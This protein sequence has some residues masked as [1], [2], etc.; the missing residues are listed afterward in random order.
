MKK[1]QYQNDSP[2]QIRNDLNHQQCNHQV[3][4]QSSPSHPSEPSECHEHQNSQKEN[5]FN[6]SCPHCQKLY[7]SYSA[8]YTHKMR[9]HGLISSKTLCLGIGKKRGRPRKG[10]ETD[11][12]RSSK[13]E[14]SYMEAQ[15]GITINPMKMLDKVVLA[16][17]NCK[18]PHPLHYTLDNALKKIVSSESTCDVVFSEY[19]SFMAGLVR[20]SFYKNVAKFLLLLRECVNNDYKRKSETSPATYI[21]HKCNEFLSYYPKSIIPFDMAKELCSHFCGWLLDHSYTCF[22]L[23]CKL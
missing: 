10:S 9:K 7:N 20:K 11:V 1:S 6:F 14:Y 3:S 4:I 21:P 2:I 19:L 12:S 15:H 13:N 8:L 22:K 5:P 18:N 16:L 17:Y 23:T